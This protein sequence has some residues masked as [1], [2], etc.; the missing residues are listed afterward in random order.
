MQKVYDRIDFSNNTAPALNETNL[1]AMSKGLDDLDDRV[2]E[3]ANGVL[4]V[5]PQLRSYLEQSDDF[6]TALETLTTHPPYIGANGNWYVWNTATSQFVDSEVDASITVNIADITIIDYDQSPRITNTGTSTDPIFHLYIPR[7]AGVESIEKTRSENNVDTYT[8]TFEDGFTSTFQI[9]NGVGSSLSAMPDTNIVAPTAGQILIY[10]ATTHKWENETIDLSSRLKTD[11][12]NASNHVTLSGALTVGDRVAESAIGTNSVS[13]GS[14]NK[15]TGNYSH[16]EG[17]HSYA[18]GNYSHA[19]GNGTCATNNYAHAEGLET[20]ALQVAAHAEGNGTTASG[21]FS[22]AQGTSSYAQANNSC[23]IGMH[24]HTYIMQN[25]LYSGTKNLMFAIGSDLNPVNKEITNPANQEA[26]KNE[27][28]FSVDDKGNTYMRG[29][30]YLVN[31]CIKGK[32]IATPD[33]I[34]LEDGAI[35]QLHTHTRLNTGAYRGMF[36]YI[37]S[38]P[39]NPSDEGLGTTTSAQALPNIANLA[40]AGTVGCNL[41]RLA[42]AYT[43]KD[44]GTSYHAVIGIGSCATNCYVRYTLTKVSGSNEDFGR[45]WSE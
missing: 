9:T 6:V 34:T 5:L 22:H 33:K 41:S 39:F 14:G 23:A 1:N 15:A 8:I 36:S 32:L 25:E 18:L 27:N 13:E 37:I 29:A 11:G 30:P 43:N 7:A 16:A 28:C 31:G 4:E 12:S 40:S 21:F 3:L 44:G 42:E 26:T 2:L 10:N 19:E 17:Y 24:G 45:N 35:Y 38:A 20:Q